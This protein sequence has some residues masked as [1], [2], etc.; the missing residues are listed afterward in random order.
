MKSADRI[1]R[2]KFW[3]VKKQGLK[4]AISIISSIIRCERNKKDVLK[5]ENVM[6]KKKMLKNYQKNKK[7]LN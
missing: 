4:F 6:S 1:K 7:H 3:I 2:K 5:K